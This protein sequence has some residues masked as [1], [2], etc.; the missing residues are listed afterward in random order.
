MRVLKGLRK[1]A[2]RFALNAKQRIDINRYVYDWLVNDEIPAIR[3]GVLPKA[4][5][6]GCRMIKDNFRLLGYRAAMRLHG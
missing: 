2:I 1:E 6:I 3:E 4:R 5:E